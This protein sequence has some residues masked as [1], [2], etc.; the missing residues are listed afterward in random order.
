MVE[1][2]GTDT[3]FLNQPVPP[4]LG[5]SAPRL[6]GALTPNGRGCRS[7]ILGG[8]WGGDPAS[9]RWGRMIGGQPVAEVIRAMTVFLSLGFAGLCRR[10]DPFVTKT[11]TSDVECHGRLARGTRKRVSRPREHEGGG[12]EMQPKPV[13]VMPAM[14][15]AGSRLVFL[16]VPMEA[17]NNGG[18]AGLPPAWAKYRKTDIPFLPGRRPP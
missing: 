10:N 16:G 18:P 13:G 11:V 4:A 1:A 9:G 17:G 2:K 7:C 3:G 14:K 12:V 5:L 8:T 6:G 15:K